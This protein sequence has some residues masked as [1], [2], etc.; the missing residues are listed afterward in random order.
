M[1]QEFTY[2][3]DCADGQVT[4]EIHAKAKILARHKSYLLDCFP[5][6]DHSDHRLIIVLRISGTDRWKC[7]RYAR[8]TVKFLLA[9]HGLVK[10][11][12]PMPVSVV[13][14]PNLRGLTLEEGR[15]VR[16]YPDRTTRMRRRVAER[17][18]R[19]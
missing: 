14:E 4:N 5:L 2:V 10:G 8:Q 3:V 7:S 1:I 11:E 6:W 15:T 9:R 12:P 18:A 16:D 19:Q 17:A 13:T